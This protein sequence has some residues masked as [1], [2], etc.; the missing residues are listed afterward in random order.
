MPRG[1]IH[2]DENDAPAEIRLY[3]PS[4][5]VMGVIHG[6]GGQAGHGGKHDQRRAGKSAQFPNAAGS[7]GSHEFV[8]ILSQKAG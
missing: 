7:V 6:L 4:T 2:V 3:Y 5:A 8:D 1:V